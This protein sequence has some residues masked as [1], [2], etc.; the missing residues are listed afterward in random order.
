MG[1]SN[2]IE[3]FIRELLEESNTGIIE[4]KRNEMAELLHIKDIILRVKGVGEGI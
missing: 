2:I 4:I 1:L 3:G